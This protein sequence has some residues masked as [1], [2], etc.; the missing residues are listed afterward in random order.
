MRGRPQGARTD[1]VEGRNA[2]LMREGAV[3]TRS[4]TPNGLSL[5]TLTVS[6]HGTFHGA[7]PEGPGRPGATVFTYQGSVGMS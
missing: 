7:L 1:Q 4:S 6:F 5:Y 2:G 3:L